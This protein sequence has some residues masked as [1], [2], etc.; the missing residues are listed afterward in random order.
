MESTRRLGNQKRFQ[1]FT[2]SPDK[3]IIPIKLKI[4]IKYKGKIPKKVEKKIGPSNVTGSVI[5]P[6]LVEQQGTIKSYPKIK[7]KKK[8]I[9]VIGK[10]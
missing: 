4:P 8:F 7:S 5:K 1:A 6:P 10:D 3:H 9:V 2:K